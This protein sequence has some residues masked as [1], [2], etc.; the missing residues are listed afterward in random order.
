MHKRVDPLTKAM[1]QQA[2][3]TAANQA[4]DQVV[5]LMLALPVYVLH[6]KCGWGKVRCERLADQMLE[7]YDAYQS[8]YVTI[9]DLLQVL[10][11]EA[12]VTLRKEE[13]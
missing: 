5:K 11:D 10:E 8:G 1:I 12:G 6:D 7:L 3:R 2:K 4:T 13:R 9:E